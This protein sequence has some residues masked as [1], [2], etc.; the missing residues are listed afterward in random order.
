MGPLSRRTFAQGTVLGLLHWLGFT[1]PGKAAT[2]SSAGVTLIARGRPAATL[3]TSDQPSGSVHYAATELGWHIKKATGIQPAITT[4]NHVSPAGLRN[5]A[6]I[7]LGD[8]RFARAAGITFGALARETCIIRTVGNHLCVA[9]LD[10]PGSALDQ[11]TS[12]GTLFGVYELLDRYFGVRWLWPGELGTFV[13]KAQSLVIPALDYVVTPRFMQRRVRAGAGFTS[14]EHPE[15]GF[16]AAAAKEYMKAQA[17]FLR[18]HRMGRRVPTNYGHA[19]VDWWQRYGTEH[20]EWFQLVRGKRGPVRLG[21]RFSM[22]IS[23]PGLR[24]E[25]VSQ[26]REHRS[27]SAGQPTFV[28]AV[29]N[30]IPGQCE[31]EI[32]KAL[33]GPEPP[34]YRKFIPSKSKIASKPFVSDRYAR[35]WQAIQRIAAKD[36]PNAV[37]VGYAYMNYFAAPTSGI[38]LNPNILIGFCPSAWYYPRSGEEQ[39]WIKDQWRGWAATTAQVF[40]RTNYFLDGYCMPHIF[41]GQFA[42]E[43][44]NAARNGMVGT[45]FD[46]LTGHWATQGPNLYLLMRLQTHPETAVESLLSEYYSAFGP[47]ADDVKSYFDYWQAYTSNARAQLRE[48]FEALGASRWRSWAKAAHAVYPEESFA[49]A[50]ALLDRAAASAIQDPEASMRVKFLELGLQHAKLCSRA[51]SKLT[52]GDPQSAYERGKPELEA[53]LQFRRSYEHMWISNMNHCA[54]VESQSWI[55]PGFAI[56]S[57]DLDPE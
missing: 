34:D 13:P 57:P 22:C 45:D 7:F 10:H 55:L 54:W 44:Q 1:N 51:A 11:N 43:F 37:V 21:A 38:K 26:W 19:F 53:L 46:S 25:I 24:E 5:A 29:E 17:T 27:A 6:H 52:L 20:P 18:R 42:D 40:M 50:E 48:G 16:T 3:V 23:N 9:G 30:D 31:C 47:A 14:E 4:E 56:Q 32:C 36:D 2:Q 39:D 33:D 35:S 41:A 8:T 28:N 49:P 15:M 12:A